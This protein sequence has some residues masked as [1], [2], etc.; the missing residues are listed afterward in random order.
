MNYGRKIVREMGLWWYSTQSPSF[1]LYYRNYLSSKP[2][3][4][5]HLSK[6]FLNWNLI[7]FNSPLPLIF[8]DESCLFCKELTAAWLPCSVQNFRFRRRR[9][10]LWA[11][12]ILWD[13][14]LR[15]ISEG[16]FISWQVPAFD[17]HTR[18]KAR[19]RV[20]RALD[21]FTFPLHSLG[22]GTVNAMGQ[23]TIALNI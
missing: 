12:E 15:Q 6:T 18:W 8:L 9:N 22:M 14:G 10:T 19:H 16:E 17:W 20:L 3:T 2:V 21:S 7:K 1:I 5:Y 23:Y 13:I 4:L 11:N